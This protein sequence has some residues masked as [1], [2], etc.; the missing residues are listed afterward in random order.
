MSHVKAL[1]DLLAEDRVSTNETLR[2]QHSHDESHFE[3]QMPDIVVF[4]ES[5]DD[6]RHVVAYAEQEQLPIVP[7]GVGSGLE[8]QTTAIHGGI[9]IDFQLMNKIVS[10]RPGDFYV[11]VQPGV[12]KEQLNKELKKHG[13]FFSVDPGADATIGGMT[14]TGASGTTSVRYGTMR[15]QIRDIEV[16]L[17]NGDVMHSGQL[18]ENHHQGIT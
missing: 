6:V 4:P 9:S 10:V 2:E 17:A 1:Q 16:V 8:G 5:T 11:T 13:L 15:Q 12:T 14:A 7:F 18:A 3:P